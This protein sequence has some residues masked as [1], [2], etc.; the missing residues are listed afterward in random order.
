[1][2]VVWASSS[3]KRGLRMKKA[4]LSISV[5]LFT[6]HLSFAQNTAKINIAVLNL[7]SSSLRKAEIQALSDRLRAE[8][9]LVS[10]QSLERGIQNNLNIEQI[11]KTLDVDF[12]IVY[13]NCKYY[14]LLHFGV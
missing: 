8:S 10:T 11:L 1:V 12:K 5:I 14:Y 4:L 13:F 2:Q 3:I 6:I 9:I 7:E